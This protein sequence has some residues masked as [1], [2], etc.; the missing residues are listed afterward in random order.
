VVYGVV[1]AHRGFID[2]ESRINVGT[3]FRLYLP[4]IENYV[5]EK[6]FAAVE[7]QDIR[8]G[9]ETI[10]VVEDEDSLRR[11][12]KA[13][14]ED[15]GYRALTAKDG[16]EAIRLYTQ[17]QDEIALV[18]TD[19]GLPRIDGATA[20]QALREINP[21]LKAV[22]ASGFLDLK[23]RAELPDAQAKTFLEKPYSPNDVLRMIRYVLDRPSQ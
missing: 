14:L 2:V 6:K 23:S 18:F 3:T 5:D 19:L 7:S 10:L 22:F 4:V 8:G 12:M 16:I 9:T 17:H 20:V 15:N 1:K 11:L 21:K 13:V